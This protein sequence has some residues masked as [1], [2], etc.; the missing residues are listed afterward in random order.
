MTL[1][2]PVLSDRQ[3]PIVTVPSL[4][5]S[6]PFTPSD[7]HRYKRVTES[8]SNPLVPRLS[9][10][11]IRAQGRLNIWTVTAVTAVTP[12]GRPR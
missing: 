6:L 7:Q 2:I 4:R 1:R 5:L 9:K 12:A 8:D 10:T 3:G 11:R